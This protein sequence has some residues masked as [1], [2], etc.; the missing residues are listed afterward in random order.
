M[1]KKGNTKVI[2]IVI[3]VIAVIAIAYF[4]MK[5]KAIAPTENTAATTNANSQNVVAN[6]PPAPLDTSDASIDADTAK[7]D[8]SLKAL[9]LDATSVDN[10]L[11]DKAVGQIQL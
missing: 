5:S 2:V 3:I 7:V 10:S 1:Y 4:V 6:V 11:N 8:A 9:E